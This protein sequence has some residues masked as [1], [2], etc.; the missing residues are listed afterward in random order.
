MAEIKI[1]CPQCEQH[2]Q[3]DDSYGGRQINCPQC[4][5]AFVLPQVIMQAKPAMRIAAQKEK[6][7]LV[8]SDGK[9]CGPYTVEELKTHLEAGQFTWEDLAWCEGMS[10]W[11]PLNGIIVPAGLSHTP[12]PLPSA[13]LSAIRT[14]SSDGAKLR[15]TWW[16]VST[17]VLTSFIPLP[18][19]TGLIYGFV[20]AFFKINLGVEEQIILG[21]GL[22]LIGITGGTYYSLSYLTKKAQHPDWRKCTIPSI[23]VATVVSGLTIG[24]QT[25]LN[26]P[27]F[28]THLLGNL[29]CLVVF[30]V[31]TAKAFREA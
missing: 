28:I 25:C 13:R 11:Q 31:I 1:S 18:F 19:V 30:S 6:T 27:F 22:G 4:Q 8:N 16:V 14:S 5:T 17:H 21:F 10:N 3:C 12:P 15:G 7:Y 20:I 24:V 9:Q 2:I 29:T 26:P 23:V